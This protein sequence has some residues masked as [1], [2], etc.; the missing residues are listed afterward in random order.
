ML[1]EILIG[2]MIGGITR[3]LQAILHVTGMIIAF[4]SALASALLFDASQGSKGS[5]A[6]NFITMIGIVMIFALMP[7]ENFC[8]N[9]LIFSEMFFL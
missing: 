4:Q 5:V 1:P 8:F 9:I 2:L 7:W 3:I 6:G